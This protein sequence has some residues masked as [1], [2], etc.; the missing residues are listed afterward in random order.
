MKGIVLH[1]VGILT[2]FSNPQ[3]HMGQVPFPGGKA[4]ARC[5]LWKLLH[6]VNKKNDTTK[7]LSQLFIPWF[8]YKTKS[9]LL[10]LSCLVTSQLNIQKKNDGVLT[11]RIFQE[12]HVTRFRTRN[13]TQCPLKLHCTSSNQDFRNSKSVYIVAELLAHSPPQ[14][15]DS[16]GGAGQ[17]YRSSGDENVVGIAYKGM[18]KAL[19]LAREPRTPAS[20]C[21]E[22]H[23][24]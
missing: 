23:F 21:D 1:R 6:S 24:E 16:F 18:H 8:C 14:S 17:K 22:F 2:I 13:V 10:C 9:S 19:I 20:M 4:C 7:P 5:W 11:L 15:C 12:G 3:W